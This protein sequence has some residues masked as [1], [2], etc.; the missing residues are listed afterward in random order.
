M[1]SLY[2]EDCNPT[3]NIAGTDGELHRLLVGAVMA[4]RSTWKTVFVVGGLLHV[5]IPI[6]ALLLNN[7]VSVTIIMSHRCIF[8]KETPRNHEEEDS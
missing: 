3:K 2:D 5:P 8:F 1:P 4:P 7:P 6:L